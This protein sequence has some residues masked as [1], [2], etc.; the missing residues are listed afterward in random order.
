MNPLFSIIIPVFNVERYLSVCLDSVINQT[1]SNFEMILVNDGSTDGS[2]SICNVYKQ[3]DERVRV[4]HKENGGVSSARNLGIEQA[5]GEWILFCDSDDWMDPNLLE[6]YVRELSAENGVEMVVMGYKKCKRDRYRPI[7]TNQILKSDL[8]SGLFL[9]EKHGYHGFLWNRIFKKEI[10]RKHNLRLDPNISFC[11]DH[12]FSFE[13][14]EHIQEMTLLPDTLYNYR[15]GSSS[16]LSN[17]YRNPWMVI[18]EANREKQICERL[19]KRSYS[20][21][22]E[23]QIFKAYRCRMHIALSMFFHRKNKQPFKKKLLGIAYLRKRG[24]ENKL[25]FKNIFTDCI[26]SFIKYRISYPLRDLFRLT[27]LHK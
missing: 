7:S 24:I 18:Q 17:C 3:K 22:F 8:I 21:E 1:F 19:L 20:S 5:K 15:V 10:I 13:Y 4:F 2:T 9:L 11:E 12:L 25:L 16:S 23:D 26:A 27:A 6:R 14:S